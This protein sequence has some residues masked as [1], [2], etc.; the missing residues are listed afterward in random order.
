MDFSRGFHYLVTLLQSLRGLIVV[1]DSSFF[2]SGLTLSSSYKFSQVAYLDESLNLVFQSYIVFGVIPMIFM[3]A[4]IF[5]RLFFL[6]E[7]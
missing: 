4:T 3:E 1:I 2:I 6:V 7:S 5:A